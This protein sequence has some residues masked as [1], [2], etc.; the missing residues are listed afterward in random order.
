MDLDA[1]VRDLVRKLGE[2]RARK[3]ETF[4][5]K[6]HGFALGPPLAES[7]VRAFEDAHGVT[8]PADFRAFITQAGASGAGP[9]HGLL[10]LESWDLTLVD[11]TR[12]PDWLARPC[13]FAPDMPRDEDTYAAAT[14]DAIEPFQGAIAIV[15]QG[16]TYYAALVVSGPH[17]GRVMHVD[18]NGSVPYF[19][20]NEDFLSWYERW[21]DELLWGHEHFWF[22]TGM[23]GNEAALVEA[24]RTASSPRR[25]DALQA[26]WRLPR[27]ED[28][29][30]AIVTAR[31]RDEE[32]GVRA[33]A[34]ALVA[35]YRVKGAQPVVR[36]AL[37]DANAAVRLASLLA[38]VALDVAW[39]DDAK[40]LLRDPEPANATRALDEL[41][42][43]R[44]LTDQELVAL[45]DEP[46]EAIVAIAIGA[47][48]TSPAAIA[49]E[50]LLAR[51]IAGAPPDA[52]HALLQHVRAGLV[53]PARTVVAFDL[54][55]ARFDADPCSRTMRAFEAFMATREL[56]S[57]AL[58]KILDATRHDDAFVRFDA[59]YVLGELAGEESF[60]A[61][62]ALEAD[63]SMP[64]AE[65]RATVWSVGANAT[66]ALG[67]IRARLRHA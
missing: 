45:L 7:E 56:W 12:A 40:R 66:K 2:V 8:L 13:C 48:A 22:G 15:D 35:K 27:L 16:C 44:A 4:G 14:K 32:S 58:G 11:H 29:T 49:V 36:A 53:A 51:A 5:S 18:V 31:I 63:A 26:M 55:V 43:T 34:L 6:A 3:L 23:P 1:R 62:E 60:E 19:V 39:H 9:Y 20:E 57:C 25:L 24:A 28:E 52:L 30:A 33:A 50:A 38:L 47:L 65:G 61:L 17:R 46:A 54:A 64:T 10:P 21:L 67:K 37:G 41:T 42:R 59:A